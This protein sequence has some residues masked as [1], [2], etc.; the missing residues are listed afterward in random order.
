MSLN[1]NKET[2]EQTIR[3]GLEDE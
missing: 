3:L 1:I 2:N